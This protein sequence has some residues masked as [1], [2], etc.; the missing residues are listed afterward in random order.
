MEWNAKFKPTKRQIEFD[1][2]FC[3]GKAAFNDF[4]N[5]VAVLTFKKVMRNKWMG[6]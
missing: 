3:H 6:T 4:D 5:D 1:L 2:D